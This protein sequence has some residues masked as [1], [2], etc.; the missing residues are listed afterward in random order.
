LPLPE[1]WPPPP[2]EPLPPLP[3]PPEEPLPPSLPLPDP[4]ELPV[5]EVV[6]VVALTELPSPP[7]P[8]P[9]CAPP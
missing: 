6:V 7:S 5:A 9:D 2:E 4:P 8:L 1:L 3:P